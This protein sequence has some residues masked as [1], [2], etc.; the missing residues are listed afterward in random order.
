[1]EMIMKVI[2]IT[3]ELELLHKQ[4]LASAM[5]S[6]AQRIDSS[7]SCVY[8]LDLYEFGQFKEEK[9]LNEYRF[10][11]IYALNF[12]SESKRK[13][14]ALPLKVGQTLIS[15]SESW[16][17][18]SIFED[19]IESS[20]GIKV[21]RNER[22][23]YDFL[24]FKQGPYLKD[25]KYDFKSQSRDMRSQDS[26]TRHSLSALNPYYSHFFLNVYESD[27][28][29][30]HVDIE[31]G[32]RLHLDKYIEKLS[33]EKVLH[34]IGYYSTYDKFMYE[35]LWQE[36]LEKISREKVD[37]YQ[38]SLR[39]LLVEIHFGIRSLEILRDV[40]AQLN[41]DV[42]LMQ[43]KELL[44]RVYICLE[45][46][47]AYP[48][49]KYLINY[50]QNSDLSVKWRTEAVQVLKEVSQSI[51][52][53]QKSLIKVD[54]FKNMK[55]K[56]VSLN[57]VKHGVS[58]ATL[59]TYGINYEMRSNDPYYLY[60]DLERDRPLGIDGGLFDCILVRSEDAIHSFSDA[61]RVIES[62]PLK[63]S[64]SIERSYINRSD[65]DQIFFSYTESAIGEI[66]FFTSI[67]ANENELY[68]FYCHTPSSNI[69][70][71]FQSASRPLDIDSM[72]LDWMSCGI[73]A[74]E[75]MK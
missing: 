75:L 19:Q 3:D 23:V 17:N 59:R 4:D 56:D 26:R 11:I 24:D 21:Y 61:I 10:L 39:M 44:N 64:R 70:D 67:R 18:A 22:V 58:G 27:E 50:D 47:K 68:D 71:I 34:F 48:F 43:V 51:G 57:L 55:L 1:M 30:S 5:S 20:F 54:R 40:L 16:T 73:S 65:A 41:E 8:C 38:K 7:L 28:S 33:I 60:R 35:N 49:Q 32:E 42:Y 31:H 63:E 29:I 74:E 66:S 2:N 6:L 45:E 69:A 15:V 72:F 36:T 52:K 9:S 37:L 13:F 25:Q 62:L 12:L 53:L 46:F 14:L